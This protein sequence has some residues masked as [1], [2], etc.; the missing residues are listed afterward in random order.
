MKYLFIGPQGATVPW[1]MK[2]SV[3]LCA[4]SDTLALYYC[5]G[6]DP[7]GGAHGVQL[8]QERYWWPIYETAPEAARGLLSGMYDNAG[9]PAQEERASE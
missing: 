7:P 6:D 8:E 9:N 1:V 4:L 2:K 5:E 3:P